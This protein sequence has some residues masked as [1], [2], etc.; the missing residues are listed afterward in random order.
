MTWW[1]RSTTWL[2]PEDQLYGG[3]LLQHGLEVPQH[4][5]L[6]QDHRSGRIAVEQLD[7]PVL[8]TKDV[9]A[10]RVHP[11]SGGWQDPLWKPQGPVVS[12]VECEFDYHHVT[13]DVHVVQLAMH[14]GER[15]PV[16][17][18]GLS[19]FVR[20]LVSHSY[21]FVDEHSVRVEAPHPRFD[22]LH[23]GNCVCLA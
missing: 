20:P 23:L 17:L 21:R 13:A 14:V 5:Q 10:R 1:C 19:N 2:M 7:L 3:V 4:A 16:V 12:S 8:E 15:R 22:V 9:A 18:N 6:A 11:V